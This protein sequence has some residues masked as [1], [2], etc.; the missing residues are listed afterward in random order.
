MLNCNMMVISLH[1]MKTEVRDLPI[2][3]GL[4]VVD[5][6][7]KIFERK[8]P[9]QKRFD[10]LKWALHAMPARWWGTHQRSIEIWREC[11]KMMRL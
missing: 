4:T 9:E 10:A 1:C 7:L 6:F 11:R 5:E 3:D 8:V 2:Y